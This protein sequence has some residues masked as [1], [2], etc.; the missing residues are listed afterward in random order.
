MTNTHAK[1]Y[2]YLLIREASQEHSNN[3]SLCFYFIIKFLKIE[4]TNCVKFLLN[5]QSQ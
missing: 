1:R 4:K 3:F 2:L 5:K